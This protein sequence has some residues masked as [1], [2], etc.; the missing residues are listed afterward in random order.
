MIKVLYVIAGLALANLGVEAREPEVGVGADVLR[1]VEAT[2]D[3]IASVDLSNS[4]LE[5][6]AEMEADGGYDSFF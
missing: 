1:T 5:V 3:S 6:P 4:A 2:I